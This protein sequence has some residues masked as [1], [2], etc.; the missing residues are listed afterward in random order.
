MVLCVHRDAVPMRW[1]I[2]VGLLALWVATWRTP[3]L[4]VTAVLAFGYTAIY[5]ATRRS[6]LRLPGD[7]SYGVYLYG[8]V[9]EQVAVAALGAH[10]SPLTVLL[11]AAPLTVACA[12]LSWRWVEAPALALK[13]RLRRR[14]VA[15]SPA[16]A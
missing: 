6:L 11:L 2:C 14:A 5:L 9:C 13:S 16:P 7:V 12:L 15:A 4:N 10:A 8:F 1:W 3:L